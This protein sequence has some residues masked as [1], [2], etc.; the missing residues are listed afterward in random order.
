MRDEQSRHC[1]LR[2]SDTHAIAGDARLSY[3]KEC[4]A[5][6]IAISDTNLVIRQAFDR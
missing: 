4:A 5:D 1:R 6:P 3:F 2:H